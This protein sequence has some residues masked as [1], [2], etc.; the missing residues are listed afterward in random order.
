MFFKRATRPKTSELPLGE[1]FVWWHQ[2]TR[3][4]VTRFKQQLER[5]TREQDLQSFLERDPK[6]L[7]QHLSGGHGRWVIPH[8]RLGSQYVTDFLIGEQNSD[9]WE[10]QAVEL[11]SPRVRMFTKKG[12]P[13]AQ[14]NHAITQIQEWRDWLTKN[15]AYAARPRD[16]QG[17]GLTDIR[18]DLAGLVLIGRRES[19]DPATNGLRRQMKATLNIEI[20]TYDFLLTNAQGRTK[21]APAG[22]RRKRKV[23]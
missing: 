19:V 22:S 18:P 13:T 15:A 20:H 5:A 4:H 8:Q 1:F 11:E 12:D 7:V 21:G 3:G 9:G 2:L 17:L 14:L 10:W 16:Q 23:R 6:I